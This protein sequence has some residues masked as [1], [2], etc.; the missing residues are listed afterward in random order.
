MMI[1]YLDEIG[2]PGAFVSKEHPRYNTSPAF[3]Y[4]G[5]LLPE[6]NVREFGAIFAKERARL[7]PHEDGQFEVKG[8]NI[9]RK[10]S[11]VHAPQNIRVFRSLA[12]QVLNFRG[13]FFYYA[14]EK[15]LGL[16]G[17][18]K[19]D[20]AEV[21]QEAMKET[22]NRVCKTADGLNS[23]IMV[24]FDQINESERAA[25]LPVMYAHI[26]GRSSDKPEMRRILEPPMHVD[27]V[28]S[29]GIQFAD[30]V[31]AYVTRAVEYQL[32]GEEAFRWAGR[33]LR[34]E[35]RRMFSQFSKLYLKDRVIDGIYH[36][37]LF[38][39]ERALAPETQGHNL[40]QSE[41][42]KTLAK[43]F[44]KAQGLSRNQSRN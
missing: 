3:G 31:A 5:F 22:L 35:K 11:D 18:V 1:A 44:A 4:A 23:N 10:N 17:Q 19:L 39:K 2:E 42:A 21:E 14:S 24:L 29:S 40:S 26:L 16:P 34:P 30:W 9:F 32:L 33:E 41:H 12:N 15:P 6:S 13:K 8:A 20:K 43:A 37:A 7:F 36:D 25:R 38:A 28:L 27:S